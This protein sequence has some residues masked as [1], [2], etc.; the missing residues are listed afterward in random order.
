VFGELVAVLVERE[1]GARV[2]AGA[3]GVDLDLATE[4]VAALDEGLVG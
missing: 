4:S 1:A 3:G 2:D